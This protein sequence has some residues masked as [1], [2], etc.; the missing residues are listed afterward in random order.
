MESYP[1]NNSS[2][3]DSVNSSPRSLENSSW[4]EAISS[5]SAYFKVKF[6]CSYGG[7][8]LPRPHDN[9]LTY[10]GGDTKILAVDRNTKYSMLISKLSS[11]SDSSEVSFKY[12]LPGEDLDALISVTNDEDLEHMMLEYDRLH[13][14]SAKPAR[15][16][17]FIFPL[18]AN[19]PPSVSS[20]ESD[21]SKADRQWFVDA[22]NAAQINQNLE[23]S[24][25][26]SVAVSGVEEP[27]RSPDFLFGLEKGHPTPAKLQDPPPVAPTVM[28]R[29]V[30]GEPVVPPAAEIQRQMHELQKMQISG[31]DQDLYRRK[32]DEFYQ[33]KPPPQA[34]QAEQVPPVTTPA[35]YWQE[36]QGPFPAGVGVG[37]GGTEPPPMYLIQT[38]AGVY[39]A[40]AMRQVPGQVGQQYF[41]VQRMVPEAYREQPVYNP[42]GPPASSSMIQQ[43]KFGGAYTSD[44]IGIG[45]VRP[46]IASE[47]G[48]AQVSYDSA[49]RQVFCAAPGGVNVMHPPPPYQ[50]VP[51]MAPTL[52]VRQAGGVLNADG[53]FVVKSSQPS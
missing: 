41:G 13:R 38:P 51:T 15:L 6:L 44:G 28:V 3:P 52:D 39:Q 21:D 37:V 42:M 45:L 17:L 27:A 14:S 16:R 47:P 23:G 18:N 8:I 12:Q 50:A 26:Q 20:F 46:P 32:V 19:P 1:L 35:T 5:S 36:R 29:Q 22:L 25:P 43:Q 49:G 40:P 10:V 31:H 33:Q 11:L 4:D 48:Y 2:Y 9:Q 53:K 24:S 30:I 34:P 7:K